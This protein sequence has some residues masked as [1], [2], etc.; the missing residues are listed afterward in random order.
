[1]PSRPS[2]SQ[3]RE[4]GADAGALLP[5]DRVVGAL[6]AQQRDDRLLAGV[7]GRRHEVGRPRSCGARRARR[8][9]CAARRPRRR[10]RRAAPGRGRSPSAR[11]L[12]LRGANTRPRRGPMMRAVRRILVA[13]VL[14]AAVASAVLAV[15]LPAR[16]RTLVTWT[17]PHGRP[18]GVVLVIH[19]GAWR[20][21]GPRTAALDGRA[22]RAPSPAGAGPRPWSTTAPSPTAPGDVV[23]AYDAAR[24]RYPALPICAY[25]ESAGGHLALMLAVRRP[26]ACVDRRR[27]TGRPAAA[28]RHA[29]GRLGAGQG[30]G[31][32]RRP[33]RRL[34]HPPRRRH[35]RARAGGL[36]APPTGSS[37]PAR[38]ATC[39]ARCPAPTSSSSAPGAG[40]RF[41]H[42]SVPPAALRAW[43]SAVRAQLQRA[44][45]PRR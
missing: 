42:A 6:G 2:T 44:A 40:P 25:G 7:V 41:V 18:A 5:D 35:P 28:G 22:A 12:A 45:R 32:L 13:A 15:S 17:A 9:P 39:S 4:A 26:L 29:A 34:P 27:R 19:G 16:G 8:P 43:W 21:S 14:A 30:A 31:R 37:R 23:R 10:A 11:I 38:A 3:R 20:A 36:R 1:M 33:A 24:E